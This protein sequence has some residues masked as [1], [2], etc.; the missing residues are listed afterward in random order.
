MRL[1][2]ITINYNNASGLEKTIRSVLSQSYKDFEY[3]VIDGGSTDGSKEILEG[4]SNKIDYWVSEPDSG[5]YNAMNKGILKANG[6]Y[7]LFINSGDTLCDNEV[8][9]KVLID[10]PDKDLV[11]GDLHRIFPDGKTDIANMPDHV[12]INHMFVSTLCHPVTFIKRSLF[13]KYGLYREDLKIVSDWAFFFKLI[14]FGRVSQV[15]LPITIASFKMDGMSSKPENQEI[16]TTETQRVIRESFSCELLNIY[17]THYKYYN[18]YNKKIFRF[19]RK[20]RNIINCVVNKRDRENYIYNHRESFFIPLINKT[21]RKQK[22]DPLSIPILIINYN[23]LAD[24]KALINFLQERKHKNIVIVDNNST[25]PPLLDY[26]K[27]IE[28]DV[29]IERM[30]KNYGHMVFWENREL[31]NKYSKGYHIITDADI[32]PN[33]NLPSNY[34]R[35]LLDILDKNKNVTKV[36]FALRI[37]DIPDYY[38]HKQKVLEWEKKHWENNIGNNL[39]LNELDTTFA[40]YPPRYK[41]D[42]LNFY[43]AIRVAGDF[44]A[45]HNGWYIDN[46]NLTEEEEYYFETANDS[47]SWKIE[48]KKIN[49]GIH[50]PSQ[51]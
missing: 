13:Q 4:Y 17:E 6:D 18:F 16:I 3:I 51:L 5:I 9:E 19:G 41:Y 20:V 30:N 44:T 39:Y 25:Y 42:L 33:E 37:D 35:Q 10:N 31:Y 34:I 24:L 15:H 23:R 40:I 27:T 11:Y 32:I 47:N 43:S 45:K 38:Q 14:A 7:L 21:V 22:K 1:S 36:G 8:L 49:N 50:N 12:D 29:T 26:Y 28:Q 46:Q 2:I 48:T